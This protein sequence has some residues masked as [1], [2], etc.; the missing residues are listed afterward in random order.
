VI[1]PRRFRFDLISEA[2]RSQEPLVGAHGLV[3]NLTDPGTPTGFANEFDGGQEIIQE[4]TQGAADC[5]Q[6]LDLREGVEA[7]AADIVPDA[8]EIFLPVR[9]A[10]LFL[11]LEFDR[12]A[13]DDKQGRRLRLVED[14]QGVFPVFVA[15][16]PDE[17]VQHG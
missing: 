1:P 12:F 7:G 8:F 17:F 6:G 14:T 4:G 2:G 11:R 9:L 10:G 15:G 13:F 16:N 3:I 5:V